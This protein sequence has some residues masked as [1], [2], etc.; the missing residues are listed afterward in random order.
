[1][2]S[3]QLPNYLRANRKRL[4]LTQEEITYLLGTESGGKVCR[5]ERFFQEPDLKTAVAYEVI[6]RR[7]VSE[8]FGG[9]YQKIEQEVAVRAKTLMKRTKHGKSTKRDAKR[10][11]TLAQLAG[12][13]LGKSASNL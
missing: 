10:Q 13:Q 1:M 3:N 8:I 5:H 2:S 7:A 12:I 9:K 11:Q 4:A 6:F